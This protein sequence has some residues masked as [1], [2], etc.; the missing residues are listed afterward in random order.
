MK[1]PTETQI[2]SGGIV[3]R[4]SGTEAQ[5]ALIS[6]GSPPRWQLPKGLI[7]K[8]EAPEAAA[9]REVR[10]ETGVDAEIVRLLDK[11]EYWYQATRDGQRVRYHKFVY[12]FLMKYVAGDVA[13]HDDEVNEAAWVP[14]AEVEARLAFKSEKAVARKGL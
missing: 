2:S 5:V 7:D 13:D 10:E 9:I 12:F 1:I 4:G 6:V 3:V 11:V 14:L 8:G